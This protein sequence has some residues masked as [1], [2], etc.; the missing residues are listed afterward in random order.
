MV[1]LLSSFILP[2]PTSNK[3]EKSDVSWAEIGEY[4]DLMKDWGRDWVSECERISELVD[5]WMNIWATEWL[6][7]MWYIMWAN[8]WYATQHVSNWVTEWKVT[9][10][11]S[12]WVTEWN[13]TLHVSKWMADWNV[14]QHVSRW[15]TA[16]HE[17]P[18]TMK[19]R[20]HGVFYRNI[21]LKKWREKNKTIA[22]ILRITYIQN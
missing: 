10:H 8:E 12:N 3:A 18:E 14:T 15:V 13:V 1:S 16:W 22:K 6:S 21:F 11:L 5:R 20:R 7:E 17:S 4:I 9:Q 2:L 19:F